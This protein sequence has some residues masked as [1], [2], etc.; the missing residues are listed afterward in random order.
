M[1]R[2]RY[3]SNEYGMKIPI[4][5]RLGLGPFAIFQRSDSFRRLGSR[6]AYEIV[7]VCHACANNLRSVYA[8]VVVDAY[9]DADVD[10]DVTVDV[11]VDVD[12]TVDVDVDV[13]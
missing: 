2:V 1:I 3:Q 13:D 6:P 7:G 9:V 11:D 8:Y 12:V 10:V 4:R 5:S